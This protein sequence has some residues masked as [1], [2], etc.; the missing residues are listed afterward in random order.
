MCNGDSRWVEKVVS[1]RGGRSVSSS[2][3]TKDVDG[4]DGEDVATLWFALDAGDRVL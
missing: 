4:W 3:E 2:A 1:R